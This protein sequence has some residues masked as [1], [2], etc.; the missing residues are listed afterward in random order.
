MFNRLTD[1]HRKYRRLQ[2][3]IRAE[4][5]FARPDSLRLTALKRARVR[6]RDE[7]EKLKQNVA[8][9]KRRKPNKQPG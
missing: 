3:E 8:R 2:E 5:G 6:L 4:Q 1:L 7:I 9:M